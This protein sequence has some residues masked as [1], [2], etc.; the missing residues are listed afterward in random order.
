MF[1]CGFFFFSCIGAGADIDLRQ[2]GSGTVKLE[3]R[4]AKDLDSLGKLDGNE[5]W[6]TV[7][8]GKA[9]FERSVNRIQGLKLRSFASKED[10]K[11]LVTTIQL[12]FD[13][14]GA[15]AA[16]LDSPGQQFTIDMNAKGIRCVFPAIPPI[17]PME[18]GEFEELL[19]QALGGY[20]F[21]LSFTL[22]GAARGRWV[23]GEGNPLSSGPAQL[24][25]G[26]NTVSLSSPMA[27]MV[28]NSGTAVL[29]IGW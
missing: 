16:F 17:S 26:G 27:D 29:E 15:L 7:P 21:S 8:V 19:T 23:D 3:Y 28:Y 20:S 22:P 5:R 2:N 4:I 6:P 14:P 9:D 10:G 25:L 24:T 1:I 18:N 13:K 11:D 12:D